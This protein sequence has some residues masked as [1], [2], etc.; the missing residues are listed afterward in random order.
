MLLFEILS[1]PNHPFLLIASFIIGI[2]VALTVHEYSH[3]W[4]AVKAGD[5]T[6]KLAGR[7]TLNPLAHLDP[8]GTVFLLLVGFGWGKPVPINPL[9]FKNPQ[10]SQALISLA[11]PISNFILAIFFGTILR[12]LTIYNFTNI[13]LITILFYIIWINIIL[14]TFNLIPIPPLDGSKVLFAFTSQ[15]T[16]VAIESIGPWILFGLL[17]LAFFTSF[18]IFSSVI[19]PIAQDIFKIVTGF[20]IPQLL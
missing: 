8:L 16:A 6:P 11:G 15:E 1:S 3:A 4:A 5:M 17:F 19:S 12:F 2:I 13:Y 9:N 18:N 10:R 20:P 7:L 14:G